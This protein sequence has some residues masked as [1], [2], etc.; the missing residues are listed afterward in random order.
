MLISVIDN[1][2][3]FTNSYTMIRLPINN[4]KIVQDLQ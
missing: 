1:N 3:K 2:D 4:D